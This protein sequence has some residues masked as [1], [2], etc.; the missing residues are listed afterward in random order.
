MLASVPCFAAAIAELITGLRRL[1]AAHLL[2]AAHMRSAHMVCS[3]AGLCDF[4]RLGRLG[5]L[6]CTQL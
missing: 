5:N 6:G 2:R 4:Q 3:E 1:H